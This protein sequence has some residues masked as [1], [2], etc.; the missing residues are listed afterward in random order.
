MINDLECQALPELANDFK[1][2]QSKWRG[3]DIT[4]QFDVDI[5]EVSCKHQEC[6]NDFRWRPEP[7]PPKEYARYKSLTPKDKGIFLDQNRD[8]FIKGKVSLFL[9]QNDVI[10]NINNRNLKT[11]SYWLK[12]DERLSREALHSVEKII[13]TYSGKMS[14]PQE[15]TQVEI[16]KEVQDMLD[17][18]GGQVVSYE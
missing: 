3:R 4:D 17:V 14:I 15:K 8:F 10:N 6:I 11:L 1:D 2:L 16:P 5:C 9:D 13:N 12:F 18:V 7:T